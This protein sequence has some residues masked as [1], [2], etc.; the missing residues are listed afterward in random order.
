MSRILISNLLGLIGAAV[1]GVA[2]FYT[3]AWLVRHGFYGLVIPGAF[4]GLGCSLLAKHTSTARGIVCAV[5]A[6]G[7]TL[8]TDW[9]YTITPLSFQEYIIDV[10]KLGPVTLLMTA[11]GTFIAF[12]LGKDAGYIGS[13]VRRTPEPRAPEQGADKLA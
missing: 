8:F 13:R 10:K 3:F 4:L 1:G 11:A 9:C 12:F 2:G 6:L 5:A 7:L